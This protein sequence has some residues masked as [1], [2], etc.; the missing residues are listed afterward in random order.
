MKKTLITLS[1][2]LALAACNNEAPAPT[3]AAEPAASATP[4]ATPAAPVDMWTR[5][6]EI[7]TPYTTGLLRGRN[8]RNVVLQDRCATDYTE[9]SEMTADPIAVREILNALH[10]ATA[11][12]ARC[13]TVLPFIGP[14]G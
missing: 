14:I 13:T 11:V 8:V 1:L 7:A 2:A 9:H 4:A 3:P 12:P 6:D 5:Y 10:P